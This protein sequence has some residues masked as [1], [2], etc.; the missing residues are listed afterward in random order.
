MAVTDADSAALFFEGDESTLLS[1]GMYLGTEVA[2]EAIL[3][4][5]STIPAGFREWAFVGVLAQLQGSVGFCLGEDGFV[6]AFVSDSTC[7]N[8]IYL[9]RSGKRDPDNEYAHSDL[10]PQLHRW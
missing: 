8:V 1:D 5:L 9:I 2:Q 4:R 7:S 10:H 6:S 3:K